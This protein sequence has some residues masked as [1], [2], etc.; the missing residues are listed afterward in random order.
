VIGFVQKIW[1]RP[2]GDWLLLAEAMCLL[3]IAWIAIAILP[4]RY[5]GRLA[6]VPVHGRA[7]ASEERAEMVSRI[8]WAISASAR[9]A[10]WRA[11]C[12][13]QGLATQ[14][15]L[16]RR[17]IHSVLYYGAASNHDRGVYAHVWVRDGDIDVIG[18]EI[19]STFAVLATFPPSANARKAR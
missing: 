9:R 4:F 11:K 12:F 18:G 6:S 13:E 16:R 19:A 17:G 15:M 1:R 10:L 2:R 3:V 8:H 14:F 7:P 5:V